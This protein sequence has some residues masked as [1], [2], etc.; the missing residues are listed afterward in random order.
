[1]NFRYVLMSYEI[2]PRRYAVG[3]GIGV[4]AHSRGG[5]IKSSIDAVPDEIIHPRFVY[6]PVH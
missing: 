3:C 6:L 4:I 1:M 2:G 5:E